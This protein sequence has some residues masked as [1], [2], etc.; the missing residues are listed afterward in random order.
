MLNSGND[1][2]DAAALFERYA[3]FRAEVLKALGASSWS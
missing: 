3:D 2:D 1:S